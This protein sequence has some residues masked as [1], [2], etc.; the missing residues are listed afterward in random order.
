LGLGSGNSV[1][2]PCG[3]MRPILFPV[4]SVNQRLPSGPRAMPSGDPA[5]GNSVIVPEGVM[6]PMCVNS[7]NQRF[8]SGPV[9]IASRFELPGRGVMVPMCVNSVNQRFPSGPVV[10][11]SRFELPGSR[12]GPVGHL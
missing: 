11:A 1:T 2:I 5:Y 8:P 4:N 12:H 10:I 9:V 7:V 3:V 6:V